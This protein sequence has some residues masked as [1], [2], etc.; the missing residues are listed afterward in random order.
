MQYKQQDKHDARDDRTK[1]RRLIASVDLPLP[2]RKISVAEFGV[3]SRKNYLFDQGD[4]PS[5]VP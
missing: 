1:R 2:K 5:H 3:E 4:Q